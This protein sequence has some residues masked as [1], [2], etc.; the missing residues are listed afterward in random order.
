MLALFDPTN[1][2]A[3]GAVLAGVGSLL[4]GISAMMLARREGAKD[5]AVK[6]VGNDNGGVPSRA[7]QGASGRRPSFNDETD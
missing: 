7:W 5:V 6:L 3:V 1:W 4:G 2:Y